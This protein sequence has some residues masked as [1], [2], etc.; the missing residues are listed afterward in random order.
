MSKWAG[1]VNEDVPCRTDKK[2]G[3]VACI[4]QSSLYAVAA[5]GLK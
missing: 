3:G 4:L 2:K 5:S 1:M